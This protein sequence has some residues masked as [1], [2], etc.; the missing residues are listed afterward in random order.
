[1]LRMTG[2]S[3][4]VLGVL[5]DWCLIDTNGAE[6]ITSSD[7]SSICIVVNSIDIGTIAA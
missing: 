7:E 2:K 5:E 6:V 3:S 1:M 4:T